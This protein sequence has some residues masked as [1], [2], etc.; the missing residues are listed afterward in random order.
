VTYRLSAR[1]EA[2]LAQIWVFSAEQWGVDQADRYIEA[3]VTRWRWLCDNPSL[4]KLRQ[5]IAEGVYSY[6]QQSHVIYFRTAEDAPG[7]IEIIR[8]L[9][10]RV[11]PAEHL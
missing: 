3:L 4:W 6:P 11:E 1:A 7:V 2:D 9:H 8:V 5:D 10:G